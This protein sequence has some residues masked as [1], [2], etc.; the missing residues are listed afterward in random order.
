MAERLISAAEYQKG[1]KQTVFT[2]VRFGNVMGSRGSVIPLFKRQIIERQEVTVTDLEMVR[3][4]MTPSQAVSLMLKANE[5]ARGGEVFV[6]KMPVVR[7]SDLVEVMI[8]EVTRK[9][10]IHQPVKVIRT[11]LRPGEK[12]Y[13]ELLSEDECRVVWE[14]EEM[15]IVPPF[16]AVATRDYPEARKMDERGREMAFAKIAPIDKETLR[17]WILTEQL[18]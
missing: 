5:M 17:D 13:E 16:F 7:I 10:R 1:P 14:T 9:Y 6:L 4:M 8:E 2:T 18:I 15:F 11:G 3:F 12:M